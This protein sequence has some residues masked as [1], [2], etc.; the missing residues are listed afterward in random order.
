M[1]SVGDL[2]IAQIMWEVSAETVTGKQCQDWNL[3]APHAHNF[4][5][6]RVF[7]DSRWEELGNK[8][9]LVC[10]N[11]YL[12]IDVHVQCIPRYCIIQC[13]SDRSLNL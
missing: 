6:I 12:H 13:I 4:T 11:Y 10:V 7:P 5:D 1:Q 9:R 8:C 2:T 3:Q